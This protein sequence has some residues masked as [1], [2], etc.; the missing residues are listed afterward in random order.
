MCPVGYMNFTKLRL[1]EK[2][3]CDFRDFVIKTSLD[4]INELNLSSYSDLSDPD[5]T[6]TELEF[7]EKEN[8][9]SG[10]KNQSTGIFT[11]SLSLNLNPSKNSISM[12]E[13]LEEMKFQYE[14]E[15][16]HNESHHIFNSKGWH[17]ISSIQGNSCRTH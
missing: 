6:D 14:S 11:R 7:I 2:L 15:P 4:F 1:V 3:P 12:D 5:L 9:G 13:P 17:W 8:F 16:L 10:V